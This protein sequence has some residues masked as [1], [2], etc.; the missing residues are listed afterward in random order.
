MMIMYGGFLREVMRT[1]AAVEEKGSILMA[2]DYTH[3]D[4]VF[5][6]HGIQHMKPFVQRDM[7]MVENELPLLVLHRIDAAVEGGKTS[8]SI[9]PNS[10]IQIIPT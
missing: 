7:L 4:P 9:E 1:V 6:K 5:S 10:Y 8:V 2:M 3:G